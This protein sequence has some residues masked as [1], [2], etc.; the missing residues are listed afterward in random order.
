MLPSHKRYDEAIPSLLNHEAGLDL[1]GSDT[2]IQA[3]DEGR[4]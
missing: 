2:D 1:V 4:C 3:E